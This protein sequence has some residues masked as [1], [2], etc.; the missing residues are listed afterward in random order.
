MILKQIYVLAVQ[1]V[2]R[3]KNL[4][5][6]ETTNEWKKNNLITLQGRM[7]ESQLTLLKIL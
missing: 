7:K 6:S 4:E 1:E 3:K 2:L 5:T